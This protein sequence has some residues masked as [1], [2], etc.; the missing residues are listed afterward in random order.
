MK[1]L[2]PVRF[3]GLMD[4]GGST[5]PWCVTGIDPAEEEPSEISCVVKVFSE[6]HAVGAKSIAKE[7]IC[8]ELAGEFDLDVPTAY[9]MHLAD[10]NFLDTLAPADRDKL[11]G[12]H[13][14]PTYC[15]ELVN[16]SLV[17]MELRSTVF[18]IQD[19]AMLFAFDCL[20]LNQD[21]GG[22]RNKPN[23][24]TDD[25][26]F[27]LIDHELSFHFIDGE[28]DGAYKAVMNDFTNGGW[29]VMYRKHLFYTRLKNYGGSKKNLFNTFEE[30]LGKLDVNK[31][32]KL[33]VKLQDI[34]IEVGA[35]DRLID[36]LSAL[37]QNSH[38]FCNL[39][40]GLIA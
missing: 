38:K 35:S 22:H 37:K 17:T 26:G 10:G 2:I 14:G 13:F 1:V 9:I 23:L 27:I 4:Q 6:A 31:I 33:I 7:F 16:A 34:G 30:Y 19:C 12:K 18:S 39:M 5:K 29:P 24:L 20:I 32:R 11:E 36:Y 3:D 40:L 21:R 25:D 15:S 28:D 8:N